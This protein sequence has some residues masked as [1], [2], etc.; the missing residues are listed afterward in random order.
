MNKNNVVCRWMEMNKFLINPD[1]QVYP[2][3]YLAN[4]GYKFKV[5]GWYED[6]N[7]ITKDQSDVTHP[8]MLDYH[9][10]KDQLNLE[11]NS[12]EEVLNHEWYQKTLPESWDSDNPHRLCVLMCSR[13]LDD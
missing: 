1:K 4:Q 6:S 3:C 7:I 2:C 5:N 10:N 12:I 8:I 11:N 13:S 9:K